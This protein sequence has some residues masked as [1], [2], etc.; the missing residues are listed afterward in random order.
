MSILQLFVGSGRNELYAD[1]LNFI[2]MLLVGVICAVLVALFYTFDDEAERREVSPHV[3]NRMRA[4]GENVTA[5]LSFRAERAYMHVHPSSGTAKVQ[6]VLNPPV[7]T[8]RAYMVPGKTA[9]LIIA[10][11]AV[12]VASVLP[13]LTD[14]SFMIGEIPIRAAVKLDRMLRGGAA[15][16]VQLTN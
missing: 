8:I 3:F 12:A 1:R 13:P 14:T 10:G 5:Q 16:D 6:I 7:E 11:Q 15:L 9:T 2:V 4:P